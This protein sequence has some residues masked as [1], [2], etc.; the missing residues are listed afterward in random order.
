MRRVPLL[1]LLSLVII[2]VF[3]N[4][5]TIIGG[6]EHNAKVQGQNECLKK[7]DDGYKWYQVSDKGR[8]GALDKKRRVIIPI[9]REY[10]LI[11]YNTKIKDGWYRK[12]PNQVKTEGW[13]WVYKND[14]AGIC[15]LNGIEIV[16]PNK[17]DNLVWYKDGFYAI[18]I[19]EKW[20]ACN[21]YNQMVISPIFDDVSYVD[22]SY[23]DNRLRHIDFGYFKVE[24]DGKQG[25]FDRDGKMIIEPK[26][27]DICYEFGY[28]PGYFK[29]EQNSKIGASD[30]YGHNF[31]EPQYD[32]L[33]WSITD[34]VFEYQD[35]YGQWVSTGITLNDDGTANRYVKQFG[36][37]K[38]TL[39]FIISML[40]YSPYFSSVQGNNDFQKINDQLIA[41][42]ISQTNYEMAKIS[43]FS[44]QLINTTI[45]QVEQENYDEYL[46][47]TNGGA[48]MTYDEWLAIKA[49]AWAEENGLIDD[50]SDNLKDIDY[51]EYDYKSAYQ[52]YESVVQSWYNNLTAGGVRSIDEKGDVSGKTVGDMVGGTYVTSK[53][54]MIEAQRN[55]KRVRLEAKKQ[56]VQIAQSKWE[57]AT[58]GY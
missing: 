35:Q 29:L 6:A 9:E 21:K 45:Q 38:S 44:Q 50:N 53:K 41:Q 37:G 31:I 15:D 51:N 5:A 34:R 16:E 3:S 56:G 49:Q 18:E 17:F 42:T 11:V 25:A 40:F 24:L 52:N 46:R 27:D 1:F 13:F 30:R 22:C 43:T 26:Y 36:A 28:G 39:P 10:E 33:L 19:N 55:M 48:T 20:G 23:L 47:M 2:L 58:A 14:K 57:T 12:F 4:C 8:Y 7:E 32:L 54:G